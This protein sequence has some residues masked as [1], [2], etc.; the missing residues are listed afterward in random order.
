MNHVKVCATFALIMLTACNG[1]GATFSTS[2]STASADNLVSTQTA[3]K[4]KPSPTPKPTSTPTPSW[5]NISITPQTGIFTASFDAIPKIDAA[6]GEDSVIGLSAVQASTYSDLGAM[7]RFSA[8]GIDVRNGSSYSSQVS[9]NYSAGTSYHIEMDVNVPVHTY[10]VYITPQGGNAA[11]ALSRRLPA[12]GVTAGFSAGAIPSSRRS[13]RCAWHP[14]R[15]QPGRSAAGRVF[16][17]G[18]GSGP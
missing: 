10:S 5:S 2:D 18:V 14:L 13:N 11:R 3:S 9:M 6:S 15:P 17:L 8:S 4:R 7:V 12:W 16:S 1:G